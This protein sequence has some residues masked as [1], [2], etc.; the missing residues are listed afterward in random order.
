MRQ[1]QALRQQ[2]EPAE[3]LA[4]S[5]S[6]TAVPE[7]NPA[8]DEIIADA[9]RPWVG[10]ASATAY[11]LIH[12]ACLLAFSLGV[13]AVDIALCIGLFYVRLFAIT[14]GY[15]RYFSHRAYKTSRVFQFGLA[16]IGCMAIQKG[17]LWWAA[18]HRRPTTR[19][20]SSS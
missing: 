19:R 12:A 5:A 15:H 11:Y 20:P 6:T 3:L 10:T 7:V 18:G 13:S 8:A 1:D 2:L 4:G 14:G 16:W 9:T 17:P